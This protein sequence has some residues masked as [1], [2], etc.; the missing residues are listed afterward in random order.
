LSEAL[1]RLDRPIAFG[2]INLS[3]YGNRHAEI[4]HRSKNTA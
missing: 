1:D 3:E 4:I 2:E